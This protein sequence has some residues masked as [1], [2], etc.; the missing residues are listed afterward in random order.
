[1]LRSSSFTIKPAQLGADIIVGNLGHLPDV[2]IQVG[3]KRIAPA[4][5]FA[6]FHNPK[7]FYPEKYLSTPII[8]I[9]IVKKM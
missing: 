2:L 3:R 6:I 8:I 1:M 4:A 9:I 5:Q 7:M